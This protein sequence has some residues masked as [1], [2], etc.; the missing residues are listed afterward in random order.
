MLTTDTKTLPTRMTAKSLIIL[1]NI[2]LLSSNVNVRKL[3]HI[4][5]RVYR[6]KEGV[7]TR[8]KL[9]KEILKE[10]KNV[11]P[12]KHGDYEKLYIE[13]IKMGLKK[14]GI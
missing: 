10:I 7:M 9:A 5:P 4:T 12:L 2:K 6:E 3:Y 8:E 11:V 1:F 14:G 13:A